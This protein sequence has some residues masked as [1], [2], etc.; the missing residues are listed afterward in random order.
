MLDKVKGIVT[1]VPG[2]LITVFSSVKRKSPESGDILLAFVASGENPGAL[3]RVDPKAGAVIENIWDNAWG[4]PVKALSRLVEHSDRLSPE[5]W[6]R[7]GQVVMLAPSM[8][9]ASKNWP[10]PAPSWFVALQTARQKVSDTPVWD[11]DFAQS[12]LVAGGVEDRLPLAIMT[13]FVA[14][15]PGDGTWWSKPLEVW[16]AKRDDHC[17]LAFVDFVADNIDVLPQVLKGAKAVTKVEAAGWLKLYPQLLP[18]LATVVSAWVVDSAKMVREAAVD[19]ISMMDDLTRSAIVAKALDEGAAANLGTVI[20]YAARSGESEIDLL[21]SAL[22]TSSG[23]KRDMLTVALSRSEAVADITVPDLHVPPAPELDTTELGDEFIALC[24]KSV[25]QWIDSLEKTIAIGDPAIKHIDNEIDR[26]ADKWARQNLRFAKGLDRG[27]LMAMRDWLNGKR[28]KPGFADGL[29]LMVVQNLGLRMLPAVRF[30]IRKYGRYMDFER[31]TFEQL[32]GVDYDLRTLARACELAGLDDPIAEVGRIVNWGVL[33][34]RPGDVWPFFAEHPETLDQ[35]LGLEVSD[36][37]WYDSHKNTAL[38]ILGMFP[39]LP[40]KYI[41]VLAQLATGEAKTFRRRAQELLATQPNVLALATQTL[42]SGKS[43][44]RAAGAAWIGRIGDPAGIEP[45]RTAL[46]KEKR[47]QAEAAMLNALKV[48]GNDVSARLT[49]DVLVDAAKKGLRSKPPA[50]MGWFPLDGLPACFWV[51]GTPVDPQI[52]RWWAQLAVKLKDPLGAG[53]IPMYVSL[54]DK[55]SQE[56]LGLFVL[57]TWIAHD[58]MSPVEDQCKAYATAQVDS[59]YADYQYL[60]KNGS[61]DD[62]ARYAMTKEQV[63]DELL[64]EKSHTCVGSAIGE[65]GLLSLTTGAPGHEVFAVCQRYMRDHGRRRAQVEA[66][67]TAASGN[68]DPAAIQLVLS[69]AR[70]FKQESVRLK[71]QE[72]AEEI[73]ERHGWSTDELADRTIP[74]AGFD[75]TGVLVLDYGPRQFIGRISRSPK[76][77]AF[78]I[79]LSNQDGKQVASLPKPGAGDDEELAAESRKQSAASKKELGQVVSIQTSRLFEAMCM[80]RTWDQASWVQNFVDHP[81]MRHLVSTLVWKVW[82]DPTG[83]DYRLFRPTPEGEL[84]NADDEDVELPE[85]ARVGLAHRVTLDPTETDQW[86]THLRDYEVNGLFDQFEATAPVVTRGDVSID[87]HRG[88]LSDTFTIRGRATKRGYIHGPAEDGGWF[89]RYEKNLEGSKLRVVIDF[90]GSM[91][92]EEQIPASVT[93]LSFEKD[94][95]TIPLDDVPEVLVAESYLDYVYIAEA[96]VYDP[97]WASKS[98]Y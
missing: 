3:M 65:K 72:L 20:D 74:T 83:A 31:W 52:V 24:E 37:K 88:W 29:P 21:R 26:L 96:G 30:S 71:A 81:L 63:F 10:A 18:P 14:T 78:T 17:G 77:G 95:R 16:K 51:D 35:I 33:G 92:P 2:D 1:G 28:S 13:S 25:G 57:T 32:V 47:E 59:R 19:L 62:A 5:Q 46:D 82:D 36:Q 75:E 54:L 60:A 86:K 67:V 53:L 8:I 91:L 79:V 90:T 84:L 94:G 6:S 15:L 4:K 56:S 48:L 49:P 42:T 73:G 70:K 87:D 58:T 69:V 22:G 85:Q 50:G 23:A 12:V 45:L 66:L 97:K 55:A 27:D 76:T 34:R 98:G 38:D 7:L 68:D 9:V 80:G 89:S 40:A 39:V 93:T 61:Y 43:E 64:R 41:P 44:I 11:P